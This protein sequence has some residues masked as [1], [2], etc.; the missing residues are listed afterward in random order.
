M[1]L[2][3]IIILVNKRIKHNLKN[4]IYPDVDPKD[5]KV[6]IINYKRPKDLL[7]EKL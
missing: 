7:I 1:F 5:V 2:T 3:L 6:N 4:R